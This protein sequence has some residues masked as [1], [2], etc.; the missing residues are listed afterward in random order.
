MWLVLDFRFP[1]C[2]RFGRSL[3]CRLLF[4]SKN[5]G[6]DLSVIPGRVDRDSAAGKLRQDQQGFVEGS[7]SQ[8]CS[9]R[10]SVGPTLFSFPT[11]GIDGRP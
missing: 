10:R 2:L 8:Q 9:G 1:L 7:P 5:G 11:G 4:T 6:D 3:V